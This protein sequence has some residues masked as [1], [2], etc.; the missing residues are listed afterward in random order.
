MSSSVSRPKPVRLPGACRLEPGTHLESKNDQDFRQPIVEDVLVDVDRLREILDLV[1]ESLDEPEISGAELA[2]RACLS[3]FHFDRLVSSALGEPPGALRRR[4]LLER[5]AHRLSVDRSSVIEI[6]LEAGYGG[7]EAFTR[8]FSRAYGVPPSAYRSSNGQGW[9]LPSANGIHFLPPGG[10][11]LPAMQRSDGMDVLTRMLDHHLWLSDQI[12]ERAEGLD[13]EVLDR[14]IELSVEGIDSEPTLR[15]LATRLV[16]QLEM[17]LAAFDGATETP[18]DGDRS[19]L[20][21]RERLSRAAP[22]FRSVVV[23]AFED[24]RADETFIDATCRPAHVF[25]YGGVVAHVL[26]YSAVRRTMAIGALESAGIDDLGAGDPM[27]FVGG[28]GEDATHI[29]RA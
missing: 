16:T 19:P 1:E 2:K 11:R 3:R 24:G 23:G 27:H 14:P 20:A 5:S 9:R 8:A 25:T 7:P 18:P 17:W 28:S 12:L 29:N 13:D 15:S 21:L 6:A 4:I 10:I 26:T 22:R